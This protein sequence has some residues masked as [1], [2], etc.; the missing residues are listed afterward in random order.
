M[1]LFSHGLRNDGG[2]LALNYKDGGDLNISSS[3]LADMDIN[4]D[5]F[6]DVHTYFGSCNSATVVNEKSFASE[7]VKKV[8]GEAEAICDPT[9][10]SKEE[11]GQSSYYNINNSDWKF[12]IA[13]K[14]R[15]LS[16][17]NFRS[18]GADNY[19]EKFV[20][21][22]NPEDYADIHW[23]RIY[24][25]GRIENIKVGRPRNEK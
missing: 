19:P 16:G 18:E 1:L 14:V 9:P 8:G 15:L 25:D 7:W 13:D 2:V 6:K 11:G 10:F 21:P 20:N 22:D 23:V 17:I 4:K 24:E 5:S 12:K 3:E